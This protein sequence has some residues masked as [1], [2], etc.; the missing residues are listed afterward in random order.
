MEKI[1]VRD[2]EKAMY[3]SIREQRINA[4][5]E[6]IEVLPADHWNALK[7]SI[8]STI[9]EQEEVELI[10][11]LSGEKMVGSVAL[12][13]TKTNAYEGNIEELDY[14]EIRMLAV[15]SDARGQGVASALISEC[16]KR[17][18][19]KRFNRIGLHTGEFMKN[20]IDLY[21]KMGF[22][23]LPQYD[24]IPANDGIIV[25]AYQLKF[26]EHE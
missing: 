24:F 1:V 4:Y 17:T 15:A 20:A 3:P 2:A 26:S 12:F 5:R 19:V 13:P 18:K 14:P 25:R 16:I 9:A 21:E 6:Y 10:V 11:A 23:R 8:S 7:K 22:Q